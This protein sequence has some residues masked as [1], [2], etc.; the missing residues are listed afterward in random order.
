M[1]G[2]CFRMRALATRVRRE[3]AQRERTWG[4]DASEARREGGRE[5][6]RPV[7]LLRGDA[8]AAEPQ[9]RWLVRLRWSRTPE[10]CP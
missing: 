5:I 9:A 10:G 2:V 3:A 1:V 6:G 4:R 7:L 8:S